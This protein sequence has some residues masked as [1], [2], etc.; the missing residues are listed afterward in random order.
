[1]CAAPPHPPIYSLEE[2]L[3]VVY[4]YSKEGFA[5]L[6]VGLTEGIIY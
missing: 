5:A 1:M 6:L 3:S 2:P 4:Y